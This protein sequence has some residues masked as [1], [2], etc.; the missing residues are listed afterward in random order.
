MSAP[1]TGVLHLH[2]RFSDGE[3]ELAELRARFEA[4]GHRFMA[5]TEHAEMLNADALARYLAACDALTD[6]RFSVIPGLEFSYAGAIHVLGFGVRACIRAA[7][8]ESLAAAIRAAGGVAVLAHPRPSMMPYFEVMPAVWD[9][10]EVWNVKYSGAA[11]P[12]FEALALLERL[13][14]C[15]G[16]GPGGTGGR[17]QRPP[18]A[19]YGLDLHRRDQYGGV[20]VEIEAADASAPRVLAALRDGRFCGRHDGRRLPADGRLDGASERLYRAV[21]AR[22]AASRRR[23]WG[24]RLT[25]GVGAA[26]DGLLVR[27]LGR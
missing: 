16:D 21:A 8:L 17:R 24:R 11:A 15:G 19:Y 6:A 22:R 10:I 1:I 4:E 13:R 7:G 5:V 14:G 9:G 12:S 18:F 27:L 26:L 3:C 25:L 2:S 20:T 23:R